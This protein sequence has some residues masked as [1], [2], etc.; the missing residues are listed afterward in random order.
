VRTFPLQLF[1]FVLAA[2]SVLLLTPAANAIA[3]STADGE[4]G[5]AARYPGDRGIGYDPDV[6]LAD[7]FESYTSP[8]QLTANWSSV[9]QLPNTRIATEAGNYFAGGKALEF[10]LPVSTSE[11]SNALNK[12]LSPAQDTVFIRAYTKFDAGYEVTGSNH[13]GLRLSGN[14][15]GPGIKA[16]ADGTGFFLF[17]L[18]DTFLGN[19][20]PGET[21]PG[22]SHIYAYWPRQRDNFGDHW[23][24]DGFV[25]PYSSALGA[26]GNVIGNR[27]DWQAFS[28]NYPDFQIMPNFLPQ[29][30][31]WYC[32]ELMVKT[33]TPGMGDGEVKY[34]IDG[35]LISDFP[36]LNIRSIPTLKIDFAKIGLHAQH[37]ERVNKKWYDNVVI[38]T[39]Y[40]G[41]M[42]SGRPTPTPTPTPTATPTPRPTP[43]ATPSA[44][45]SPTAT[46]TPSATATPTAT[47]TSTPT[48]T[49]TPTAGVRIAIDEDGNYH[50]RDDIS[51][52]ALD[53]AVLAKAGRNNDLVF[54]SH[55]DHY[56]LTSAPW[57]SDMQNSIAGGLTRFGPFPN[58]QVFNATTN[59]TAAVNALRDQINAS[60]PSNPLHIIANGPMQVVGEAINASIPAARPFVT[61]ISQ[62][63]WNDNHAQAAGP[64]EG[65]QPPYYTFSQ[66]PSMGINV[67]HLEEGDINLKT[68]KSK[69]YW[70][71]DS[72][73]PNLQ[74]IYSRNEIAFPDPDNKYD[75]SGTKAT[76]YEASGDGSA[77]PAKLEAY[78]TGNSPTPTPTPTPTITPTPT[79]VPTPTPTPTPVLTPTPTPVPTPTPTPTPVPTPI[80]TPTPIG[81]P[82]VHEFPVIENL[83]VVNAPAGTNIAPLTNGSTL[84]FNTA[85]SIRADASATKSVTFKLDGVTIRT[86]TVAPYTIAGNK[87]EIYRP[88]RPSPGRHLLVVTPFSGS[89]A[90]GI[91]GSPK[92]VRFTAVA[93]R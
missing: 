22:Y 50:D 78:L 21:D 82:A 70:L 80:P 9:Y 4:S 67:K 89:N 71:R 93:R 34:W 38:A 52:S 40:I 10:S 64:Q 66:F 32:Y 6:I 43:S 17:L 16:P 58:V 31:R 56:W 48:P 62:S 19:G 74:W 65:L 84:Y 91:K 28:A 3:G 41:P 15:P 87:G 2:T 77:T 81:T 47:P 53:T 26:D 23:F 39:K 61:V 68:T 13:D 37:S 5:L 72:P 59:H 20:R 63:T 33:N 54:W 35:K 45:P 11:T 14:Y 30:N 1:T 18:Q 60:G 92:A 76:Y 46:P 73:D 79:P 49:P 7:D 25:V 55:S 83:E 44:T 36:N 57:E 12:E 86:E 90:S 85:L 75:V 29:R 42:A 27:G 8:S 24:P 88:W 69:F 51:N